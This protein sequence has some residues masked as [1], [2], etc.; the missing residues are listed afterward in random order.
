MTG[1]RSGPG[2]NLAAVVVKPP[3]SL[4]VSPAVASP[5]PPPITAPAGL[6]S[7]SSPPA[8]R[9]APRP[10]PWGLIACAYNPGLLVIALNCLLIC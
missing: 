2:K 4:L 7:R 3:T 10:A 5:K 1:A 6:P 8:V 9:T